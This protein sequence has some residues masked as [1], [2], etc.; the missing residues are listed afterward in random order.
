MRTF[1]ITKEQ[2][3]EL[4]NT[5]GTDTST[6]LRSNLTTYLKCNFPEAFKTELEVGKWYSHKE[7][8]C[9]AFVEKLT[10]NDFIGYGFEYPKKWRN[11]KGNWT[12]GYSKWTLATEEEVKTALIAEA[13]RRGFKHGVKIKP[14][15]KVTHLNNKIDL[16]YKICFYERDNE[17]WMGGYC[18]FKD[19]KWAEIISE[20]I[21]L[22]LE[23]IAEKFNVNVE[24]LKIKK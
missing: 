11:T 18:L 9:L 24:Q 1:E 7:G 10:D 13:K 3:L 20:P 23:Q 15:N 19:G 6:C 12:N 14:I 21:E 22:T 16:G 5:Y 4:A 17:F 2:I 8:E